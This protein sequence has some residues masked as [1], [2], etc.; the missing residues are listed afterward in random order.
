M[1]DHSGRWGMRGSMDRDWV[2]GWIRI[3]AVEGRACKAVW[4]ET[5]GVLACKTGGSPLCT[6]H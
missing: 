6:I 3:T 2:G 1:H 4:S 5:A